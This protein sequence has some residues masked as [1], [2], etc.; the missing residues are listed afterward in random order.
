MKG[1][2]IL[3]IDVSK[4]IEVKVGSLGKIKF[5]KGIYAYVGSAQNNIEKR[6]ERHKRKNKKIF[7]HIDYLLTNRFAK[8]IKVFYKESGKEEECRSA[9]KL[10]KTEIP[11]PGF[12]CSDCNCKSHFFKIKKLENI[13]KLGIKEL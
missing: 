10:I 11:I 4:N 6:V 7:W 8:V 3:L 5:N 1:I 2:Y 9:Q 13:K 12:G